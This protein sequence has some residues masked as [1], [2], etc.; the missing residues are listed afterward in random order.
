MLSREEF[1]EQT[2]PIMERASAYFHGADLPNWFYK[3]HPQL[4]G[5][6]VAQAINSGDADKVHAILDR[7]DSDGYL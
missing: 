5:R 3:P 6:S 2:Q 7:L 1:N 4:E